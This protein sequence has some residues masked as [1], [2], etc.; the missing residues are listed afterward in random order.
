VVKGADG[1]D[2]VEEMED[3]SQQLLLLDDVLEEAL[4]IDLND[5]EDDEVGQHTDTRSEM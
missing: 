1:A 5:K 3:D 4:N 2:G